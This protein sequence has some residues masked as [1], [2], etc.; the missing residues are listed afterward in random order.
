MA[1]DQPVV[2]NAITQ[3]EELNSQG[4]GLLEQVNKGDGNTTNGVLLGL[5]N[6][7]AVSLST[8]IPQTAVANQKWD[9][10]DMDSQNEVLPASQTGDQQSALHSDSIDVVKGLG[11]DLDDLILGDTR[12]SNQAPPSTAASTFTQNIYNPISR[13]TTPQLPTEPTITCFNPS[14]QTVNKSSSKFCEECGTPFVTNGSRAPTPA[15]PTS[16][17]VAPAPAATPVYDPSLYSPTYS[18]SIPEN[19]YSPAA[20]STSVY[21]PQQQQQQQQQHHIGSIHQSAQIYNTQTATPVYNEPQPYISRTVT[22]VYNPLSSS[23]PGRDSSIYSAQQSQPVYPSTTTSTSVYDPSS[24]YGTNNNTT[25][26]PPPI[27]NQQQPYSS[28]PYVATAT[29]APPISATVQQP[30]VDQDPLQRYKGCPLVQFGF[31]GKLCMMFPRADMQYGYG[32]GVSA[33]KS[34]GAIQ[35]KMMKDIASVSSTVGDDSNQLS[36]LQSFIGPV[37]LDP[38]YST[39]NKKKQVITYM[40]QRILEMENTP[41]TTNGPSDAGVRV[42]L[43]K[44]VKLMIEQDGLPES[45]TT[46]MAILGLLQPQKTTAV[47]DVNNFSVPAYGGTEQVQNGDQDVNVSEVVLDKLQDYLSVGDRRGAV[48]YAIQEDLWSHALIISSCVDRDLWQSVVRGFTQRDLA[49]PP[50]GRLTRNYHHVDGNRQ[51]LRVLYAL[52]SGLGASSMS[53]FFVSNNQP[54]HTMGDNADGPG[55]NPSLPLRNDEL[56][57]WQETLGL[58]YAN[59]TTKDFEAMTALGDIL[60]NQGW[61]NASHIW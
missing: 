27:A 5:D 34:P 3:N 24:Y 10:V 21:E 40:E 29:T 61:I 37:L 14:C 13:T 31:G 50:G 47:E 49:A 55:L 33:K 16:Q 30:P 9:Q 39:K 41:M 28:D 22:P 45:D 59:R 48:N 46:N 54:Q 36:Y 38:D 7:D 17:Q 2:A 60:K 58:M 20:T 42:L 57:K 25:P 26:V 32:G 44:I 53:E 4:T 23:T 43:W 8:D 11:D 35:I 18:P 12:Q 52:F 6:K 56:A 19:Q 15:I 51:G 1:Q